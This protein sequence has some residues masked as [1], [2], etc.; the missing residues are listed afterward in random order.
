MSL[1]RAVLLMNLALGLGVALGY[2]AWG[3][4]VAGLEAELA[5]ARERS[6][7]A[8]V[9]R[10]FEAQGVI[11]AVLSD[12]NVVVLSHGDISGFMPSM[13]MGFRISDPQLLRGIA[14]GDSVRFR[15]K[16]VPPNL[17]IV[18]IAKQGNA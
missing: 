17:V 14:V 12:I 4:Q 2:L 11:R 3:R 16:G 1:W 7:Q 10:T 15:L 6:L 5:V 13:T 18:A 8:G 9:E